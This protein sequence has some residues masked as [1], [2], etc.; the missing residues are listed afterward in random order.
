MNTDKSDDSSVDTSE[1]VKRILDE[2]TKLEQEVVDLQL[3]LKVR[4]CVLMS[5]SN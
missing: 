1:T 3:Q 2:N 5:N 4:S